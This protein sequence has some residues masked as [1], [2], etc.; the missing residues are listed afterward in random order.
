MMP[1]RFRCQKQDNFDF[2]FYRGFIF[3]FVI[4]FTFI[5][6]FVFVFICTLFF[7][8]YFHLYSSFTSIF[9]RLYMMKNFRS[10]L[11]QRP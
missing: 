4:I 2:I 10:W 1:L 3:I 11:I 6:I 5:S 8:F 7:Y 9:S